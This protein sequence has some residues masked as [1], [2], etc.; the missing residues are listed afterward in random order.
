MEKPAFES[1]HSRFPHYEGVKDSP[2][3]DKEKRLSSNKE[4]EF[5]FREE[6]E[7]ARSMIIN[8]NREQVQEQRA[9]GLFD[10]QDRFGGFKRGAPGA[11]TYNYQEKWQK[12]S[13]NVK[14]Q[15]K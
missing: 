1:S 6:N 11:G 15:K 5:K 10:K 9:K 4:Q 7:R 3:R 14:Y 2:I 12:K 13:Y 8:S